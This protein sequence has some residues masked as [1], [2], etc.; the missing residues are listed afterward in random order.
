MSPH[1]D[2]ASCNVIE[3]TVLICIT[4]FNSYY[5]NTFRIILAVMF[6]MLKRSQILLKAAL[7][8]PTPEL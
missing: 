6:A 1:G 4:D 7:L 3:Y 8:S 5:F 2:K